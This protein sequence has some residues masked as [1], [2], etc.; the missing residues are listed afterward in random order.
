MSKSRNVDRQDRRD[1]D[2]VAIPLGDGTF[3]FGRVLPS[4]MLFYSYRS[5][6]PAWTGQIKA[7]ASAFRIFVADSAIKSG[8]WIII[9]SEPLPEDLK[10]PHEYFWQDILDPSRCGIYQG[11][12]LRPATRVECQPLERFAIWSAEHVESRLCDYFEG[13]PNEYAERLKLK[14]VR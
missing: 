9:H 2:Y 13:R 5:S 7:A 3:A 4:D 8:R 1:G 12:A 14:P 11:G 10:K 6:S